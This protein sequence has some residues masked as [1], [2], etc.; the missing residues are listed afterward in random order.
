[1]DTFD[2]VAGWHRLDRRMLFVHPVKELIR[3]LPVVAGVVLFGRSSGG[4]R[5]ALLGVAI[6]IALGLLRYLGTSYRITAGRVELRRGLLN[7]HVVSTPLDRVRTVDVSASPIHR[8]LGLVTLQVGTGT[9]SKKGENRIALDGVAVARATELRD[10]LLRGGRAE[11]PTNP[12]VVDSSRLV[13]RLDLAWVRFAPLTTSGLVIAG[14]AIGFCF[15]AAHEVQLS[16]SVGDP[17]RGAGIAIT[18]AVVVLFLLAALCLLAVIGYVVSNFGLVLRHDPVGHAWHLARGLFT[19]RET[20]IDDA[21][22]AG[23]SIGEPLGLRLAHGGRLSAIVTGLDRRQRGSSVLVPPAPRAEVDRVAVDVLGVADPVRCPLRTHGPRA[24]RRRW[25]RALVPAAALV[26]ADVALAYAVAWWL[27]VLA[28]PVVL[29]A[30]FLAW[31]RVRSLGHTLVDDHLVARSGSLDRRREVLHTPSVI[32]WNQRSTWFQRRVGLTDLVAT[33][34][35]GRQQVRVLDLDEASATALAVTATPG[36]LEPFLGRPGS[37]SRRAC[38][39][40]R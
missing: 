28:V 27:L 25:T 20:T 30:V 8:L 12:G 19:T 9:A 13:L 37:A 10:L 32:G 33:T 16:V 21:R 23:V 35:G 1:M 40:H 22:V 26:V 4:D 24:V 34:A 31:D 7:K 2:E 17:L 29:V 6:P 14:A 15:Q 5:W 18:T 3:F 38:P 36:L 39:D 11:E